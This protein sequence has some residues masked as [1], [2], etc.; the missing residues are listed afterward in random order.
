MTCF[1]I[2]FC[3]HSYKVSESQC[4]EDLLMD[5]IPYNL[6]Q[7]IFTSKRRKKQ[8]PWQHHTSCFLHDVHRVNKG[9][10]IHT[11]RV[12]TTLGEPKSINISILC[13]FPLTY[14]KGPN[15]LRT[16]ILLYPF[17]QAKKSFIYS[18]CIS[19][20]SLYKNVLELV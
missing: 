11:Y 9:K 19:F 5:V 16:L 3:V 4:K 8:H 10:Y 2:F 17:T 14:N 7:L 6:Q 20:F 13:E 15:G 1:E 12:I 18:S